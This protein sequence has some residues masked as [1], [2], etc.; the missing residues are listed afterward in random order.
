MITIQ[1]ST[2]QD[3]IKLIKKLARVGADYCEL[4]MRVKNTILRVK[5]SYEVLEDLHEQD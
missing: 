2:K 1:G 4:D 3:L 5:I